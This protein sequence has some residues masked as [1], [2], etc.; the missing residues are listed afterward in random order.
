ME[1]N[2]VDDLILS[3]TLIGLYSFFCVFS[4]AASSSAYSAIQSDLF[5][6]SEC[7]LNGC[8][9]EG[10]IALVVVF[11]VFVLRLGDL[12]RACSTALHERAHHY[13]ARLL[14]IYSHFVPGN[15][16]VLV[17]AKTPSQWSV[18]SLAPLI[19]F[20]IGFTV[21][22]LVVLWDMHPLMRGVILFVAIFLCESGQPSGHNPNDHRPPDWEHAAVRGSR[23]INY[24]IVLFTM[25]APPVTAV[26][27]VRWFSL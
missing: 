15:D 17:D 8:G 27:L 22:C 21:A 18:T 3:N 25:I 5:A 1:K 20:S 6:S 10:L 13:M 11:F 26:L 2:R 16:H 19:I 4:L 12:L 7:R 23:L 9:T 24:S 14:G